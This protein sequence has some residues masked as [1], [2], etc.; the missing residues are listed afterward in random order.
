MINNNSQIISIS[1]NFSLRETLMIS[2]NGLR[3][4]VYENA[5]NGIKHIRRIYGRSTKNHFTLRIEL[6]FQVLLLQYAFI[7]GNVTRNKP[8]RIRLHLDSQYQEKK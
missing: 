1:S 8:E 5:V 6:E 2:G 3:V 7:S 4:F